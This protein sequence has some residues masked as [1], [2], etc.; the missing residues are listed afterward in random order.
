MPMHPFQFKPIAHSWVAIHPQPRGVIQFIGGA[1]FGTFPT[2]FYRHFL[3]QLFRAG[4]TIAAFPFRF[5]FRHWGIAASLFVEQQELRAA[6][7]AEVKDAKS[8]EVYG[9]GNNYFW[10]GHSLGCKYVE[11]LE[12]LSGPEW[13]KIVCQHCGEATVQRIELTLESV[14]GGRPVSICGQASLLMAPDISDTA[15]AIPF[16]RLA[17]WFD[18]V[19]LGVLPTRQQTQAFIQDSKLFNL[20]GMISFDRDTVA[21]SAQDEFRSPEIQKNSD[22]LW[23]LRLL[24]QKQQP[25]RELPGDH[26][27][28]MGVAIGDWVLDTSP[29]KPRLLERSALELLDGLSR[30]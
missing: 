5:S 30:K 22:V 11:L 28:P 20:T 16:K 4:Y 9:D 15:S 3:E 10:V 26:L 18:Q 12:F 13:R 19:G 6:L 17:H 21:G 8:Q 2:L 29:L 27:E 25:H 14:T 24:R 7:L 1:F 23:L